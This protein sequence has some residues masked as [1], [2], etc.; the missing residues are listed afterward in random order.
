MSLF[1]GS[2]GGIVLGSSGGV[3][4]AAIITAADAFLT[5]SPALPVTEV[6]VTW[7]AA[8]DPTAS[9]VT[10]T[11][12]CWSD[13]GGS[14][15]Y[16]SLNSVAAGQTTDSTLNLPAGD[17]ILGTVVEVTGIYSIA[18]VGHASGT[19]VQQNGGR[20]CF[21]LNSTNYGA[22]NMH[23]HDIT[24]GAFT[25]DI[26]A[27][28]FV[29][30]ISV[31]ND[32]NLIQKGANGIALARGG[33]IYVD[34][35]TIQFVSENGF[36]ASSSW[37]KFD[38]ATVASGTRDVSTF[39]I[40][41][42]EA[43]GCGNGGGEHNL[44]LHGVP[45]YIYRTYFHDAVGGGHCVKYDGEMILL[46]QCTIDAEV[47][48]Y[49][50]PAIGRIFDN[51]SPG[52]FIRQECFI[53]GAVGSGASKYDNRDLFLNGGRRNAQ[54]LG[55]SRRVP[56]W[57]EQDLTGGSDGNNNLYARGLSWKNGTLG[58]PDETFGAQ[59]S[60][61]AGGTPSITLKRDIYLGSSDPGIADITTSL[62]WTV[63][64]NGETRTATK[65]SGTLVFT[66]SSA[67]SGTP[68]A[69]EPVVVYNTSNGQ[70]V[71]L[72]NPQMW[73]SAHAS[74]YWNLIKSGANLD[75]TQY[76][77]YALAIDRDNMLVLS[78]ND[79]ITN[80]RAIT[81]QT[82]SP[83]VYMAD[84]A[85]TVEMP[86]PP[87]A[88]ESSATSWDRA[89]DGAILWGGADQAFSG[90]LPSTNDYIVP[91][92]YGVLGSG[93]ALVGGTTT[94]NGAVAS[95]G[96]TIDQAAVS[97]YT[98]TV[99]TVENSV[100]TLVSTPDG[101]IW[102]LTTAQTTTTATAGS[103]DTSIT[104]DSITG[105]S[106]GQKIHIE[107]ATKQKG[108][109]GVHITTISG[110]P[111]GSTINLSDALE[112]DVANGAIV[113]AVTGQGTEPA[114]SMSLVDMWNIRRVA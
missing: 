35:V 14:T 42:S 44:Y 85:M 110:T 65:G 74:Y 18:F 25:A 80:A 34:N 73:D 23:V 47:G 58:R 29:A 93:L 67:F 40:Y 61:Y 19:A 60:S 94:T 112:R 20:D 83:R 79:S 87:V 76:S 81:F 52:D 107:Y 12:N 43:Y 97:P 59:V 104:V 105:F 77:N 4:S 2:N 27:F 113:T 108:Q 54:G 5:S 103:P 99:R 32:Y 10:E 45:T 41:N 37:E 55:Y 71:P 75:L 48:D 39:M 86:A 57:W 7:E 69:N 111:T 46:K 15:L 16:N 96:N 68:T 66:L 78:I 50:Q 109:R 6:T 31:V 38:V 64:W 63:G 17:F 70:D 9:P 28:N 26:A 11:T 51:T 114:W 49:N 22:T 101:T 98:P 82:H 89:G 95:D 106:D 84:S 33:S 90:T 102:W 8:G 88:G 56:T 3:S 1:L 30:N 91:A 24:I 13:D 53:R 62:Y 100:D 36:N 21:S 92:L 72:L